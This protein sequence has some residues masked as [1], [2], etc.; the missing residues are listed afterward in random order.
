MKSAKDTDG[1]LLLCQTVGQL[2][3]D[4]NL[5]PVIIRF[6]YLFSAPQNVSHP[7]TLINLRRLSLRLSRR[8]RG[9]RALPLAHT[10]RSAPGASRPG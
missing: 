1:Q 2:R 8:R 9:P 4:G 5:T 10:S 3:S 6:D 7:A